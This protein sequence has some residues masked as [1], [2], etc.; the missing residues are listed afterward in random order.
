MDWDMVMDS[1]AT[2]MD[3]DMIQ[4]LFTKQC[5]LLHPIHTLVLL[6]TGM[7]IMVL[8]MVTMDTNKQLTTNLDGNRKLNCI[9]Y[10][11]HFRINKE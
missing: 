3:L 10:N 9:N 7:V 8:D 4:L 6:F 5:I 1:T 11:Y 2:D